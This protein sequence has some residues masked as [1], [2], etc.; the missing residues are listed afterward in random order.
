MNLIVQINDHL[1]LSFFGKLFCVLPCDMKRSNIPRLAL[2]ITEKHMNGTGYYIAI[3]R[4]KPWN[5]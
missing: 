5:I 2:V 4:R 3:W 1:H